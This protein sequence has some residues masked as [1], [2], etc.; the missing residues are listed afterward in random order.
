MDI[1]IKNEAEGFIK[2]VIIIR[3]VI[4]NEHC[5]EVFIRIVISNGNESVCYK[6]CD[7]TR[8]KDLIRIRNE[9]VT[10]A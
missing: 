1:V 3:I 4:S 7:K 8:L 6:D 5:D 10:K 9:I 2:I